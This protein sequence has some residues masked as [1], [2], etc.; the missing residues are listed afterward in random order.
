[1]TEPT[2]TRTLAQQALSTCGAAALTTTDRDVQ[3]VL[4]AA[5]LA[6]DGSHRAAVAYL[7]SIAH[8]EGA[9]LQR[10]A[11]VALA[12]VLDELAADRDAG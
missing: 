5:S 6:G 4:S 1:M 12:L 9:L 8:A 3:E 2:D 10:A 11:H 7:R